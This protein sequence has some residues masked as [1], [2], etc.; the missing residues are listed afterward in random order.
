STSKGWN[1][2]GLKCGLAIADPET[3]RTLP[4]EVPDRVGHLGVLATIAALDDGEDWLDQLLA[5][6]DETRRWLPGVLAAALPEIGY[7]PGDATFLAWLDCRALGLG[8][9]PAAVFLQ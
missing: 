7:V 3:L 1:L 5:Y 6:L 8:D 2:A 9:D 4:E